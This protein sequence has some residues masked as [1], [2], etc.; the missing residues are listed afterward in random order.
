MPIAEQPTT[1]IPRGNDRHMSLRRSR[2]PVVILILILLAAGGVKLAL[3]L[4]H[5][6]GQSA[7]PGAASG[8]A[9][10]S[11]N[12]I[13]AADWVSQQVSRSAIV[14]CDP[15][16]CSALEAAGGLPRACWYS[17]RPRQ[18]QAEPR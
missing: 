10:T 1:F 9:G 6:G 8:P 15:V 13:A 7:G 11:R 18:I 2:V 5:A 14:A 17:E 12:G 16:M 3:T 4:R